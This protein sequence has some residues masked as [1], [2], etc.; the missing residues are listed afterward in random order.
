[1]FARQHVQL[2]NRDSLV[3]YW[4]TRIAEPLENESG[5]WALS[6]FAYIKDGPEGWAQLDF[7]QFAKNA[8]YGLVQDPQLRR[9]EFQETVSDIAIRTFSSD[10]GRPQ[11][12]VSVKINDVEFNLLNE[13]GACRNNTINLIAFDRRSTRPYAGLYFKWYELLY[14]Y[15]GRMLLCGREPYVI[16]S[17]KPQELFTGLDDDIVQ[18]VDNIHDGDSVILF[19]IGDAGYE[20]W[21]EAARVAL[22]GVGISTGQIDALK[23]GEPVIIFGRKGSAAGTALIFRAPSPQ[24]SVEVDKTIAGRFT[25][26]SMSSVV[27]G[28]AQRWD[29]FIVQVTEKQPTDAL[30]FSIVGIAANGHQ[31]TL[32]TDITSNE[33]LSWLS[34][35]AYPNIKLVFAT[36]DDINLTST[37]LTKWLV[38]F[39]PVADGLVFYRGPVGR[40]TVSEGQILS[41][42]FGFVN[43]SNKTFAD[44]LTVRHDVLNH[45]HPGTSP[46]VL[47]I[48]PPLP[49]DTTLFTVPFKTMAKEGL[50]DLEVFVNPRVAKEQSYDNNVVVLTKHLS[51]IVDSA[52]PVI[53]VTFDGRYLGDNEFVSANPEIRIRLWD[54]G[55]FIRKTDTLGIQILLS[56]PCGT[57][58]CAFRRI[59][60]SNQDVAWQPASATTDFTVQFTPRDLQNGTYRLRVEATDGSGNSS[61]DTPY[62][63]VFRVEHESTVSVAAAHPNPFYLHTHFDIMVSGETDVPYHYDVQ[64]M[65]LDGMLVADFSDTTEGLHVGKNT[66]SWDGFGVDGKSLPNGIYLYRLVIT[67]PDGRREYRGKVVL[68]R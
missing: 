22:A 1:V 24:S 30:S 4:R 68:R 50:N 26:G 66:I 37:Q 46:S 49:G 51:V 53:E 56:Y 39:E 15:G 48:A 59:N 23:N 28:P 41:G 45:L 63:I 6:S 38:A 54:E 33:D 42:A 62:E 20:Q 19:N 12:S 40:Q 14:E 29:E 52:P 9:I 10:S 36:A 18:Y 3:Y 35:D 44:S 11:D 67:Q 7:P 27:I 47:K 17:F 43:I 57:E 32:K 60:F 61:G 64:F 25:T 58:N 31:D 8:T 5:D 16:N 65:A 34:A 55:P 2:L 21:P 13:G